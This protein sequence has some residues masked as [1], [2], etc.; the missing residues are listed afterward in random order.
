MDVIYEK[1]VF[2]YRVYNDNHFYIINTKK[3]RNRG[4]RNDK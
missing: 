2:N 4:N 3:W 1:E